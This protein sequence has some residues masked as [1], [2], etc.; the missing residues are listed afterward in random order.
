[1][2]SHHLQE[3]TKALVPISQTPALDA[4]ILVAHAIGRDRSYVLSHPSENLT[5]E[6]L[7]KLE[8]MT[9]KR[10][11]SYPVPYLTNQREFWSNNFYVDESVLI[12]RPETELLVEEAIRELVGKRGQYVVDIGTGSG[13]IAITLAKEMPE[14]AYLAT[15]I[16]PE[17]LRTAQLNSIKHRVKDKVNFY[18]GNLL[19]PLFNTTEPLANENLLLL[20]NLPYVDMNRNPRG[21]KTPYSR[22]LT[23][24]ISYEPR[25]ALHG[26]YK[27]LEIPKKLLVQLQKYGIRNSVILMEIGIDQISEL[28]DYTK[29]IFPEAN[30]SVRK[31]LSDLER[32]MRIDL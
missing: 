1:M 2:L 16:S 15:D 26:G 31:D 30:I 22:A 18:Q 21:E 7:Q 27:G 28:Y 23:E 20:A 12:P 29:K 9:K 13:C 32:M 17:A 4:E 5:T 24:G 10:L 8:K 11:K 14:H 25:Q 3:I 19:D 6:Q